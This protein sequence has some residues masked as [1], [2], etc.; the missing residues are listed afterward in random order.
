MKNYEIISTGSNGNCIIIDNSIMLETGVCSRN[1]LQC[2]NHEPKR[3]SAG[4]FIWL[5]ESE[6]VKSEF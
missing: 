3:K 6:V 5:R 2:I 4:G 1:I